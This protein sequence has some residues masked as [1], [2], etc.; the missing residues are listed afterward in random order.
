MVLEMAKLEEEEL[1]MLHDAAEAE[2]AE[3]TRVHCRG[4]G[5]QVQAMTG[6]VPEELEKRPGMHKRYYGLMKEALKIVGD[7]LAVV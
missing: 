3:M 5:N 6:N 1:Y 4:L 2:V 7:S